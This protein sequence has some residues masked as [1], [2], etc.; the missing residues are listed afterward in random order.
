MTAAR[1]NAAQVG[2]RVYVYKNLTRG[3]WSLKALE[4]PS[5]GRVVAHLDALTLTDCAARV[6]L[7][8][9]RYVRAHRS[10]LVCAGIVGT[11][12]SFD[13]TAERGERI[14]FRPFERDDMSVAATGET[15]TT[16]D[17]MTFDPSGAYRA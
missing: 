9:V 6:S 4:G 5:K 2:E 8:G 7:S 3:C 12:A 15:F 16:A 13:A 10:R 14:T 17:R 1:R 11:L